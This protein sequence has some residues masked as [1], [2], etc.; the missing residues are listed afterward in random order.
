M[1]GRLKLKSMW[2]VLGNFTPPEGQVEPHQPHTLIIACVDSRLRLEDMFG[3]KANEAL[4]YRPIAALVPPY[5]PALRDRGFEALLCFGADIKGIRNIILMVHTDCGGAT[6]A[7]L[8]REDEQCSAQPVQVV[9][10]FIKTSELPLNPLRERFAEAT[11]PDL[12]ARLLGIKSLH[13]LMTYPT[14]ED[15]IKA[16][17]LDVV[18][19]CYDMKEKTLS[20]FDVEQ[21]QWLPVSEMAGRGHFCRKVACESCSCTGRAGDALVKN[22]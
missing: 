9:R 7:S 22:L 16:G 5:D 2:E 14:I 15:R 19:T 18:L 17:T 21:G 8:P 12:V 13:N 3:L 4:T 6:L 11:D 10:G 20:A 1:S